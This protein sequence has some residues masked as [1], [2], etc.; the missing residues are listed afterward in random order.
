MV[1]EGFSTWHCQYRR[2]RSALRK[3]NSPNSAYWAWLFIHKHEK[4]PIEAFECSSV[5]FCCLCFIIS[6]IWALLREN[7]SSGF[8]TRSD[9]NKIVQPNKMA[10]GLGFRIKIEEERSH[11]PCRE[12]KGTD[13]P[14]CH[15]EADLRLCFSHMQKPV[16]P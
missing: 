2:K 13:R 15:R 6:H 16:F 7:R 14:R 9:T 10:G 11:Y 12:N 8:P 5:C 3:S 1:C 4:I